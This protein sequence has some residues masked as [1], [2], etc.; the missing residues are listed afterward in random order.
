[1]LGLEI[2]SRDYIDRSPVTGVIIPSD[3]NYIR[4]VYHFNINNIK[5]YYETRNF[6][7]KN[8]FILSRLIEHLPPMLNYDS[9]RY[10]EYIR[11]K[12]KYLGKHFKFTSEIEEGIVH[13]GYFF[14]NDNEEIIFSLDEYFNPNFAEKNWKDINCI[15]IYKHEK[16][17]LNML[18]PINKTDGSKQGLCVIGVNIPLLALKYREF[19][20]EQLINSSKGEV[21]LNKNHFMFKY[22]LN[23]TTANSLDNV[24]MN[25]IMDKFYG[26]EIIEPRFK[27][28]FKLF[29]PDVQVRRYIDNTLDIITSK[30]LDFINILHNIQLIDKNNA[31]ELL[32]LPDMSMTKQVKWSLFL[33]R[34]DSCLFL[35]DVAK[36]KHLNNI[37]INS[38][39]KF[40]TRLEREGTL[41]G[42][43][44]YSLD[45]E[46]KEKMYKIKNM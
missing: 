3:V 37:Y 22:V 39:K 14:G 36:N 18:L 4:R 26:R 30:N 41:N 12:A 1:M 5:N 31:S 23:L 43:L 15:K 45:N 24:L 25:R 17:D 40:I 38:W 33:T 44:S 10:I 46:L 32:M 35:F 8:T 9:Y 20:R 7:I 6:S 16:N 11:D 42:K 21:T 27:H 2:F 13:P 19:I 29:Y 34:L 28:P